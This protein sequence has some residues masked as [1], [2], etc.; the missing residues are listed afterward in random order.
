MQKKWCRARPQVMLDFFNANLIL[1][2]RRCGDINQQALVNYDAFDAFSRLRRDC[3]RPA[4]AVKYNTKGL[5]NKCSP[6]LVFGL[7]FRAGHQVPYSFD[8]KYN[9]LP[10]LEFEQCFGR[11]VILSDACYLNW[12]QGFLTALICIAHIETQC[13][14]GVHCIQCV[15]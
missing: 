10:F 2:L 7:C 5:A 14:H 15:H 9:P 8:L 13:I 6:I 11:G 1:Q 3:H 12:V 4:I